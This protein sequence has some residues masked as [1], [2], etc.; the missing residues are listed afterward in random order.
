MT[1]VKLY[2]GGVAENPLRTGAGIPA[3]VREDLETGEAA[4]KILLIARKQTQS[5]KQASPL[6]KIDY[7]I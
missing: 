1:D 5:S 6:L 3:L 4:S 2:Y 7:I